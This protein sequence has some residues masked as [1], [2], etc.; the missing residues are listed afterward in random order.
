M[1]ILVKLRENRLK[2]NY[3]YLDIANILNISKPFYW[4]IENGKRRLTYKKKK[5]IAKIFNMKPDQLF[6]DEF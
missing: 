1:K 3:T 5:K 4:Q 2:N 6:Y